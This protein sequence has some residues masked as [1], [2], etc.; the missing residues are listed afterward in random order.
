MSPRTS[1]EEERTYEESK[2]AV[3]EVTDADVAVH[4]TSDDEE[5]ERGTESPN[6]IRDKFSRTYLEKTVGKTKEYVVNRVKEMNNKSENLFIDLTY[7]Q[8][9]HLCECKI[10][11]RN[12]S[13][14]TERA[15]RP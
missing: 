10:K 12:K 5:V 3:I 9:T 11:L 7:Y 1:E 14:V 15:H 2:A 13:K 8:E 4:L 6:A